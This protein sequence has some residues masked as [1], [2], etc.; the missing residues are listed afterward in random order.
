M[1]TAGL[2]FFTGLCLWGTLWIL[3]LVVPPGSKEIKTAYR[4]NFCHGVMSSC[5]AFVCLLGYMPEVWTTTATISYFIVDFVNIILNDFYFQVPSYQTPG[6]RRVEYFHHI[7]CCSAAL[8]CE[9]S[10]KSV[11]T[12]FTWNPFIEGMFAELSTPFLMV[13]RMS[14]MKHEVVG[15]LFVL[16]FFLVRIVYHGF[17]FTPRVIL[18]CHF[19]IGFAFVVPYSTMNVYFFYLILRKLIISFGNAKESK[20]A[21]D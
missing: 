15:R 7:L 19:P 13:W 9:F 17:S 3:I 1:A 20:P 18:N 12:G 2:H 11:C 10:Y 6:A 21:N 14:E 16:V 4:L 5:V 8:I